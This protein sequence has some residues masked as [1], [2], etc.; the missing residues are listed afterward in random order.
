MPRYILIQ[1]NQHQH[2]GW[3]AISDMSHAKELPLVPLLAEEVNHA[4]AV[5]AIAFSPTPHTESGFELV[6]IQSLQP[7][8]NL[9]LHTD[10]RWLG[11]YKPA[12]YRKYPFALL[13]DEEKKDLHLCI[14]ADSGLFH[15]QAEEG[16]QPLL[17]EDGTPTEDLAKILTFLNQCHQNQQLTQTLITALK[18][19]GLIH[20]WSLEVKDPEGNSAPV[21]GLFHIDQ[22]AL[23]ELAPDVLSD[24]NKSGALALAYGQ[25]MSEL[26]L[27]N[28]QQLGTIRAQSEQQLQ[29]QQKAQN[30]NLDHLF[31]EEQEEDI[32]K[33]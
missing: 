21:N 1:K 32:F 24:L 9:Y 10:G 7:G 16:D 13:P 5:M 17:N 20:P 26:K 2:A 3:K 30:E 31:G 19:A 12:Y 22:K 15:E 25:R 4:L 14:D 23:Q 8:Q 33:F 27:K 11:G 6:G 18:E 28:L 29:A